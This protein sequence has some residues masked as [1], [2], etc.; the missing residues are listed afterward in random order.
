MEPIPPHQPCQHQNCPS[1]R[2]SS[3]WSSCGP[4]DIKKKL[5]RTEQE[6]K[7]RIAKPILCYAPETTFHHR[8]NSWAS[9]YLQL[10]SI[11][12]RMYMFLDQKAK[13]QGHRASGVPQNILSRRP[14][15]VPRSMMYE[16]RTV[17]GLGTRSLRGGDT[18]TPCQAL[19]IRTVRRM[20][21]TTVFTVQVWVAMD[22]SKPDI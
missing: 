11:S 19:L 16:K 14:L 12:S 20:Q 1:R 10:M 8:A 3:A 5:L 4:G 21:E 18:S 6:E 22:V 2:Q 17:S 7:C 15:P 9:A 13:S